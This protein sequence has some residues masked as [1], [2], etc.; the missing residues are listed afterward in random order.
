VAVRR[1]LVAGLAALTVLAAC[2]EDRE[3]SVEESGS[4]TTATGTGTS[5]TSTTPTKASGPV[6][7]RV[8]VRETEFELDPQNPKIAKTG[9]VEFDVSNAG[10][11]PHALEVE[12]PKGEV[13]TETIEPGGKATLRADLSRAGTYVWY[14]PVGDHEKQGMRG[15][16]TVAGGGSGTSTDDSEGREGS[17]K[18]RD[19]SGERDDSG[20]D[21]DDSGGGSDG[22]G[23][24]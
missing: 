21:R 19:D 1:S 16:I 8:K 17:G 11:V 7:D 2:G 13:E 23:G 18:G 20:K 15:A 4:G 24:Y 3:G 12:G 10:Q 9:V 5:G 6:V 14:C 22:P